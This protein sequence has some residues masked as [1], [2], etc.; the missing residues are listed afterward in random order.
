MSGIFQ[1]LVS[2]SL[3][4]LW[5]N[6][7]LPAPWQHSFCSMGE[8]ATAPFKHAVSIPFGWLTAKNAATFSPAVA[9]AEQ[10]FF[11]SPTQLIMPKVQ[12]QYCSAFSC[13]QEVDCSGQRHFLTL[14]L[15]TRSPV[16]HKKVFSVA[17]RETLAVTLLCNFV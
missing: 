13:P 12:N 1:C 16:F 11:T 15:Y 9:E 5:C 6:G 4:L 2:F 10:S 7:L 8:V 3:G 14:S 17:K